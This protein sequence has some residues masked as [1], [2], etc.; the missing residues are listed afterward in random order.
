MGRW[1]QLSDMLGREGSFGMFDDD[2]GP[3]STH[4]PFS[5]PVRVYTII[6]DSSYWPLYIVGGGSLRAEAQD[7]W[8]A[9]G[10]S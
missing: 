7:D 3:L 8:Y 4:L 10:G 2:A 5:P 9:G 6:R 1:G